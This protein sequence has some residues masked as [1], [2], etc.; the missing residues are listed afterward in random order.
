M[1]EEKR[2][3]E[4]DARK[5]KGQRVIDL[6]VGDFDACLLNG[7]GPCGCVFVGFI[8]KNGRA[9]IFPLDPAACLPALD[10]LPP[11]ESHFWKKRIGEEHPD[12][13]TAND[14]SAPRG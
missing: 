4:K 8:D 11:V 9:R 12:E 6:L 3:E 13:K 1:T 5:R 10:A 7:N 14:A 2:V